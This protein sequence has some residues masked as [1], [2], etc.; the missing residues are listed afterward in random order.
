MSAADHSSLEKSGFP[1]PT[2]SARSEEELVDQ[3]ASDKA[4]VRKIDR[5]LV[6]ILSALYLVNFL[7]R[8]NIGNAK[9]FGLLTDLHVSNELYP[10]ALAAFYY[11]YVASQ[12]PSNTVLKR[13]RPKCWLPLICFCWGICQIFMCFVKTYN[14]LWGARVVLGALEGGL[15]PGVSLYITL[16]YPKRECG[17]RGAV[18]FSAATVAGAFSGLLARLFSLM[19]GLGGMAGWQWIWIMEGIIAVLVA[20]LAFFILEDYPD[21]AKFLT[22]D[23]RA[24]VVQRL[25]ED[26]EGLSSEWKSHFAWSAPKDIKIWLQAIV[27]FCVLTPTYGLSLFMPTI[28]AN[29]GYTSGIANLLTV[30]PFVFGCIICCLG[31]WYSDRFNTRFAPLVAFFSTAIVGFILLITSN[32]VAAQYIGTFLAAAGIYSTVPIS[33]MWAGNNMGGKTKRT[34]GIGMTICFGNMGGVVCSY[35][36]PAADSPRFFM[37]YGVMIGLCCVGIIS[38]AILRLYMEKQNSLRDAEDARLGRVWDAKTMAE[39]KDMGDHA[40]F[41]R[42][43]L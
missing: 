39:Y 29:M 27:F 20:V 14:E 40:P 13:W 43:K 25:A 15:F 4:L 22:P 2:P 30:P 26:N 23:E 6:P 1:A 33:S 28:I 24:R 38:C 42:Y 16:W 17:F 41:F 35:L 37:G 12:I 32:E 5:R 10:H 19:D 21:T 3:Q 36:F 31:G 9:T 11:P 34:V 7:C 18:F 8:S